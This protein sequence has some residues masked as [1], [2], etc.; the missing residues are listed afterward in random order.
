MLGPHG[1]SSY[2]KV[3]RANIEMNSPRELRPLREPVARPVVRPNKGEG[4][5]PQFV[6]NAVRRWWKVAAPLGILVAAVAVGVVFIIFKPEYR[7]VGQIE[8][9][10]R[11]PY[12]LYEPQNGSSRFVATQLE[13]LRLPKVLNPVAYDPEVA[14]HPEIQEAS[15]PLEY[16]RKNLE[17][18]VTGNSEIYEIAYTASNPDHAKQVVDKVI[19]SFFDYVR[20]YDTSLRTEMLRAI[21]QEISREIAVTERLQEDLRRMTEEAG[22]T[23]NQATSGAHVAAVDATS[24]LRTRLI[25]AEVDIIMLKAAITFDENR[26][27]RPVE[28]SDEE[29]DQLIRDELLVREQ[30]VEAQRQRLENLRAKT[31]RESSPILLQE[32]ARLR[33]AEEGLK[34]LEL[35]LRTRF[36]ADLRS[37]R[38]RERALHLADLQSQL[39]AAEAVKKTLTERLET[40]ETVQ[41]EQA[42]EQV[43]INFKAREL[44][45]AEGV[46]QRLQ[47]QKTQLSVEQSAPQR[48]SSLNWAEGVRKPMQP[49]KSM[50]LKEMLLVGLLS[51]MAPF[52]LAVGWEL[53]LRRVNSVDEIGQ[54]VGMRVLGEIVTLPRV[55]SGRGASR[56]NSRN[57]QL[58]EESIDGLRTAL[59]LPDSHPRIQVLAMASAVSSEGKTSVAVQLSISLARTTDNPVLLIDGDMRA[60][61]IHRMF[62]EEVSPGLAEVLAGDADCEEAIIE[63]GFRGLHVLAAGLLEM[64]PHRLMHKGELTRLVDSLRDR[65]EYIVIDTPPVLAANEAL[66]FAKEADATLV[67]AMRDRT[68]LR[69]MQLAHEKLTSAGANLAGVVMSG[70]PPRSYASRYGSYSYG[71]ALR[72]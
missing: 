6:L 64:S 1:F 24:E 17:V 26:A 67:C 11:Q 35:E 66:V 38:T 48:V 61:D 68:R 44:E 23:P 25:Q 46:F 27:A 4:L 37:G 33:A 15:D 56:R 63:T 18:S 20:D 57:R 3:Q 19:D 8:I 43:E 59:V 12:L 62:D 60:P 72:E 70:L 5:T 40:V 69:H 58:F 42:G 36:R 47:Q 7:A 51:L 53:T 14:Q 65:Y 2:E 30:D 52:G 50:P 39:D 10:E 45:L 55:G 34:K 31:P 29:I 54:H 28:V 49:V 32:Q 71:S 9:L 16:L 21:D 13:L 41:S 22:I